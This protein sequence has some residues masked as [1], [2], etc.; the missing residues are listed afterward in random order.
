MIEELNWAPSWRKSVSTVT[1]QHTMWRMAQCYVKYQVSLQQMT[2]QQVEQVF[3]K[4]NV[5]K[6]IFI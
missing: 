1:T 4:F 3:S 2:G 5:F 6:H